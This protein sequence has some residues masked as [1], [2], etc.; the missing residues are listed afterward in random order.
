MLRNVVIESDSERIKKVE[1]RL[2]EL[3][4]LYGYVYENLR[5]ISHGEYDQNAIIDLERALDPPDRMDSAKA[6][7]V[8]KAIIHG[9]PED[10]FKLETFRN[11]PYD[12]D[13]PLGKFIRWRLNG[14]RLDDDDLTAF[15]RARG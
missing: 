15:L 11:R 7:A 5:G 13:A 4:S 1:A 12:E 2:I 10:K 3:G 9:T 14:M 8:L 6:V